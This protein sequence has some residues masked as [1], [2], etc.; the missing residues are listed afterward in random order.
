MPDRL[1]YQDEMLDGV[2]EKKDRK[3]KWMFNYLKAAT[4]AQRKK[5]RNTKNAAMGWRGKQKGRKD[6]IRAR[7]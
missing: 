3:I 2:G 5:G 6:K 4:K 7:E 1:C